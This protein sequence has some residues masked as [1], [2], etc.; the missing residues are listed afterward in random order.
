MLSREDNALLTRTGPGTPM[1]AVLRR[2]WIPALTSAE[3]AQPDCPPVRVK[4]LGEDLIAF[5]D[6]SGRI[7]LVQE[8]CA[9]RCASLFFAANRENGLRCPYHGWK[10]DVDGNCVDQPSEPPET[11][12]AHKVKLRAYA[13]RELGGLVWAYMGPPDRM[14]GVPELEWA[15]APAGHSYLSR[16]LQECN[17]FQAM[18]GGIDSSHI[19]FLHSDL[20]ANRPRIGLNAGSQYSRVDPHPVFEVQDTDY[21]LLIAARRTA[22]EDTYYWRVTQWIAPWYT[23]IP[24]FGGRPIGGH[25]WVPADDGTCWAWSVNWHPQRPLTDEELDFYRAGGGIHGQLMP[26]TW[27]AT[28]NARNDYLID[29]EA[30]RTGKS[31]SGIEGIPAQDTAMQ[32]SQG[33]IMD[34]SQEQLGSSDTA[35]IRT[36]RF[37]LKAVRDLEMG[38]DPP[39]LEPASQRVRSVSM[40]LPKGVPFTDGTRHAT[41]ASPDSYTI[42]V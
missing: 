6:S 27:T 37:M 36:R 25:A 33:P 29:R 42:S 4:L 39:G 21:G 30:Q 18:E 23:M 2:Y 38:I 20:G 10:Y 11:N 15:Q 41:I 16:R 7:G 14:P 35:I 17:Y 13:C 32:E 3:I 1:G 26:G 12:F 40:L 19:S 28:Q 9:H 31:L 8:R 22:D 5:R 24:P 34:R